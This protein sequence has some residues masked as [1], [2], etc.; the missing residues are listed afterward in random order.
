MTQ[1]ERMTQPERKPQWNGETWSSWNGVKYVIDPVQAPPPPPRT[2]FPSGEPDVPDMVVEKKKS[3]GWW[4]SIG[5]GALILLG[6]VG[7][8]AHVVTSNGTSGGS[9]SNA[10]ADV[11]V[12]QTITFQSQNEAQ[13]KVT[14]T[15]HSSETSNYVIAVDVTSA[16]GE[17][18]GSGSANVANLAAGATTTIQVPVHNVDESLALGAQPT[19][20]S[21]VRSAS[22]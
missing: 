15:N 18:L 12:A 3:I 6:I 16:T 17:P 19:L 4:A 8:I 7:V 1:Q 5:I 20:K 22:H 21:A 10:N 2:V 9:S 13:V 11:V 14:V